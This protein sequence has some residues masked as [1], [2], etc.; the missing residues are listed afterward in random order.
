MATQRKTNGSADH[1]SI[2]CVQ[3]K[4]SKT[5]GEVHA[6][7]G[8]VGGMQAPQ[9]PDFMRQIM[10]YEMRQLPNYV[11]INEPVPCKGGLD[12]GNWFKEPDAIGYRCDRNKPG[13]EAVKNV[14]K[15]DNLV[16]G[17]PEILINQCTDDLKDQEKRN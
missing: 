9:Q 5:Y 14:Y 1:I 16:V 12:E 17:Y 2:R 10:I 7:R 8:V 6:L 11:A 15:K 3:E 4:M 13:N